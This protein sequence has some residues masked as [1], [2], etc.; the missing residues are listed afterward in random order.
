MHALI[1]FTDHSFSTA[2]LNFQ[3]KFHRPAVLTKKST[4]F[5]LKL[6]YDLPFTNA[7][8]KLTKHKTCK[9]QTRKPSCS[10]HEQARFE[11]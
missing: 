8:L 2:F 10:R 6:Q 4:D 9:L 5:S 7:I 3:Q 1:L 11:Q